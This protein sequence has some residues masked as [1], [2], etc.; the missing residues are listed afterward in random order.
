MQDMN[1]FYLSTPFATIDQQ[2]IDQQQPPYKQLAL[3][4]CKR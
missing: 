1:P 2:R 3:E 4:A